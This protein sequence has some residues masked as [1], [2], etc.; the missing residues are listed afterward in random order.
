[1]WIEI[2]LSFPPSKPNTISPIILDKLK[3]KKYEF[4][5]SKEIIL[6]IEKYLEYLKKEKQERKKNNLNKRETIINDNNDNNNNDNNNNVEEGNRIIRDNDD[7]ATVYSSLPK[8]FEKGVIICDAQT[9]EIVGR[10]PAGTYTPFPGHHFIFPSMKSDKKRSIKRVIKKG[11][12]GKSKNKSKSKFNK[13]NFFYKSG[14]R[15]KSPPPNLDVDLDVD[16][17]TD[18]D[19]DII[20]IKSNT[21][22]DP[23]RLDFDYH[24]KRESHT[25][26][27]NKYFKV[28]KE[29]K[30]YN[31]NAVYNNHTDESPTI[32]IKV[33]RGDRNN[34]RLIIRIDRNEVGYKRFRYIV[35]R[36]KQGPER[37]K[38]STSETIPFGMYSESWE[39]NDRLSMPNIIW[40]NEDDNTILRG[41]MYNFEDINNL[42]F[43]YTES[44][45]IINSEEQDKIL[46]TF[47]KT[48]Y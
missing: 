15:S 6:Q 19:A 2:Y 32:I 12:K 34:V 38:E 40:Y 43:I 1:L 46:H 33:G 47:K 13:T 48:K 5:K 45:D 22:P 14:R 7:N 36:R 23:P 25:D 9:H 20:F 41:Y 8:Y 11:K 24:S 17:D 44:N 10:Y 3:N 31:Q 37:N 42:N 39:P 29:I 28:A 26:E 16:A 4:Y 21:I 27:I 30:K 35:Y 18:E